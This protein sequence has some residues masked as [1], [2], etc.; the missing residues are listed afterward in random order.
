MV[1]LS[2][3]LKD[4]DLQTMERLLMRRYGSRLRPGEWI[5]VSH[6]RDQE[7][8]SLI[9]DVV[10]GGEHFRFEA[11][12]HLE[13]VKDAEMST[14][15]L[16]DFL[17]AVLD[18][19]FDGGREAYPTLDFSPYE[20]QGI[21]LGLRGGAHRPDLEAAADALLEADAELNLS[22]PNVQ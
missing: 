1:R 3:L 16:M 20:F 7:T 9:M 10:D 13:D 4:V 18:E 11:Q 12:L 17:D 14:D 5:Q 2:S 6:T 19:W 22:D 21:I 15:I 8:E